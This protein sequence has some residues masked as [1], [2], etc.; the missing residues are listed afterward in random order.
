M[1]FSPHNQT[2]F[3][4]S[5]RCIAFYFE[6]CLQIALKSFP[7]AVVRPGI[8]NDRS[9]FVANRVDAVRNEIVIGLAGIKVVIV[10]HERWRREIWFRWRRVGYWHMLNAG[11]SRRWV[12][13]FIVAWNI[14]RIVM[15]T[16]IRH[17]W[18]ERNEILLMSFLILKL[19]GNRTR[20]NSRWIH[21]IS[22]FISVFQTALV[23]ISTQ[24]GISPYTILLDNGIKCDFFVIFQFQSTRR[25]WRC[26]RCWIECCFVC[27]AWSWSSS[28]WLSKRTETQIV[29]KFLNG[30][31]LTMAY[32]WCRWRAIRWWRQIEEASVWLWSKLDVMKLNCCED[33]RKFI[34]LSDQW[35][36]HVRFIKR[37]VVLLI[38]SLS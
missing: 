37:F 31:F 19:L 36:H 3:T 17:R 26:F 21:I 9:E 6:N 30:S 13:I 2:R 33:G 27:C 15:G 38:T 5:L 28:W 20:L 16:C 11:I 8:V 10:F 29:Q 24:S 32:M 4:L 34:Q 7:L 25:C 22:A 23:N 1:S 14:V 12:R 18:W 35:L